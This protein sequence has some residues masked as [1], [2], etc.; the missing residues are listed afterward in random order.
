MN[1]IAQFENGEY[2]AYVSKFTP[3][4]TWNGEYSVLFICFGGIDYQLRGTN[5]MGSKEYETLDKAIRAA[6]RYVNKYNK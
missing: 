4:G 3:L 5:G 1:T 6:K 2:K